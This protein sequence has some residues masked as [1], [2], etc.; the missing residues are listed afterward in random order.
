MLQV[1]KS[2]NLTNKRAMDLEVRKK[3]MTRIMEAITMMVSYT[4]MVI[5]LSY[6]LIP[7]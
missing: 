3:L 4:L 2:I 1:K 7:I 6:H 5:V